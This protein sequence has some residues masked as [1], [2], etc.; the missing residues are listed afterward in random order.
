MTPHLLESLGRLKCVMIWENFPIDK[1]EA[2]WKGQGGYRYFW[3]W[4][5]FLP[6]LRV[7]NESWCSFV[8]RQ[9]FNF[10]WIVQKGAIFGTG[11]QFS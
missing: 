1:L 5:G 7:L 8:E 4:Y 6:F 11:S 9:K 10:N 3:T 2:K